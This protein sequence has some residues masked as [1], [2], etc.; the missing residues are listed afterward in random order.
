MSRIGEQCDACV[1]LAWRGLCRVRTW[2][3]VPVIAI[4]L[5]TVAGCGSDSRNVAEVGGAP[6]TQAAVSHWLSV[7]RAGGGGKSSSSETAQVIGLLI[8]GAWVQAAAKQAG[9]AV[10]D[11]EATHQLEL[12]TFESRNGIAYEPALDD[13][14]LVRLLQIPAVPTAEKAWAMRTALLEVG[15][16]QKRQREAEKRISAKEIA[17]FYR[18]N[19]R[20]F[21]IQERRDLNI[22]ESFS[23]PGIEQALREVKAGKSWRNVA[24][25]LSIDPA[26]RDGIRV[27]FQR[28]NGSAPLDAAIFAAKPG[29]VMG[30]KKLLTYWIFKVLRIKPAHEESLAQ[31]EAA[32]RRHLATELASRVLAPASARRLASETTC[33]SGALATQCRQ[34]VSASLSNALS[35][36][37]VQKG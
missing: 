27:N 16:A 25:R 2:P 22:I 24:E 23:K 1:S 3:R 17:S 35:L 34:G 12:F 8:S 28:S 14:D 10:T 37:A 5:M 30:P 20:L 6:I 33:S 18:S 11:R 15:V 7:Q 36:A 19:Q 31:A 13:E 4:L 32:I 29:V 26:A 9:V 21:F